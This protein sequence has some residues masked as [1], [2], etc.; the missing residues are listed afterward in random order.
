MWTPT[1]IVDLFNSV[2]SQEDHR[3]LRTGYVSAA[4]YTGATSSTQTLRGRLIL[5]VLSAPP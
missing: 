2:W 5:I 3:L 1:W 4:R